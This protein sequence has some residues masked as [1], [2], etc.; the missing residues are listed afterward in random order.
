MYDRKIAGHYGVGD[1][2]DRVFQ[3]LESSG[4]DLNALTVD[5]LAPVD[6][7]HIRGRSATEELAE[8][9]QIAPNHQLLDV[10]CGL[11]GTARYLASTTGCEVIGIDLTDE[12]C[13]VAELLSTR[14]GLDGQTHFRQGSAL[15]MPFSEGQFDVVWTEHV[16][17]N[18]EEKAGFYGE[19]ARVL[20]ADGQ[21][22]F[23]DILSKANDELLYPVPWASDD[24]ISHLIT[25]EDLQRLLA[26]LGFEV[27]RWEDKTKASVAFFQTALERMQA[28]GRPPLGLHLL[29]GDEALTKFKNL[30]R[31]LE[32]NRL[33]VVQAVMK[34][35]P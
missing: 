10:G 18:I 31:N 6:A 7:F 27:S 12:Y 25:E 9:A 29:M 16:Q 15:E 8:W 17:M 32:E 21:F 30:F 5:D 1:I 28:E 26:D 11:G 19:I 14:V 33:R 34:R 2:G 20:K 22:A 23:H 24:S 35:K 3:A 4:K 13:R